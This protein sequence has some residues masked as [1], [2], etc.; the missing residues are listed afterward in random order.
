MQVVKIKA[1]GTKEHNRL[2]IGGK[3]VQL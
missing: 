1:V 2:L 3:E